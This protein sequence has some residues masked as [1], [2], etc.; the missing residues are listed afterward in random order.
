MTPS[1]RTILL[2]EDSDDDFVAAMRAFSKAGLANPIQRCPDGDTALDYL[3]QRKHFAEPAQSPRP[4]IILLDLNLPAM[5]GREVLRVIKD[6]IDLKK[7]P[8]IVLTTSGA[9]RDIEES[10]AAGANSYV[11]KPVNLSKFVEA[12]ALIRSY[13]LESVILP[14]Y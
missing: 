4:G 9:K 14:Q 5:D 8:V 6:D 10:Y 11:Q 1:N 3:Y 12:M 7:I 13:W 2:V